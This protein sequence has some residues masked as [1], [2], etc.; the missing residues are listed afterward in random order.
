[1]AIKAMPAMSEYVLSPTTVSWGPV[2][3]VTY[4]QR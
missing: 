2:K 1:M 4:L 3:T